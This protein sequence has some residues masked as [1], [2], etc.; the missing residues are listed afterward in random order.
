VLQESDLNCTIVRGPR[1]TNDPEKG[2]YREGWVGVSASTK[3]G[4]ADL[5]HFILKV[6]QY[7][8]NQQQIPS[9]NY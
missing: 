1:L 8:S 2:A 5:A 3:I 9:V 4:R 7:N 6:L